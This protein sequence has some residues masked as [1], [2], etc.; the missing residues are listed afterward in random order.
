MSRDFI[1]Q[2]IGRAVHDAPFRHL[3]QHDAEGAAD[4]MGLMYTP[5]DLRAVEALRTSIDALDA[6]AAREYL[7][8]LA[9]QPQDVIGSPQRPTP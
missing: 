9:A 7:Q 8:G 3:L 6:D 1:S 5:D 2:V 4:A